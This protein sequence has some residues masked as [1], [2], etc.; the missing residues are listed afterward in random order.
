MSIQR[1]DIPSKHTHGWQARAHVTKNRRLTAFFADGLCGGSRKAER[2]AR[3]V[4]PSLK[5]RAA[6]LRKGSR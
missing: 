6:R 2:A 4:E 5:R 1:I 3:A